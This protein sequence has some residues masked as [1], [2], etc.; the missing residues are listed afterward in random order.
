MGLWP[1]EPD[2]TR[3][4]TLAARA[5]AGDGSRGWGRDSRLTFQ[6]ALM[7]QFPEK[8]RNV[9]WLPQQVLTDPAP[10]RHL[11]GKLPLSRSL[12]RSRPNSWERGLGLFHG[13]PEEWTLGGAPSLIQGTPY[14][15]LCWGLR[16]THITQLRSMA[17]RMLTSVSLCDDGGEPAGWASGPLM[18]RTPATRASFLL[19]V[20]HYSL[21]PLGWT[22]TP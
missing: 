20:S 22:P 6:I 7:T 5:L 12:W 8:Q 19:S 2:S 15:V 11:A 10:P 3:P 18:Q 17:F 9:P 13:C 14:L 4:E 16:C 1:Q 21:E